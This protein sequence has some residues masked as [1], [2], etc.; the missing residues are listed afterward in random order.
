MFSLGHFIW[1][2]ILAVVIIT[3]LVLLKK[4]NVSH[5]LVGKVV[6][7]IAI[8]GKLIHLMLSLKESSDGG[9]VI[10]QTQLDFHLCSIQV[11]LMITCHL[12]KNQDTV[13]KIKGFMA[14]TMAIGA[15][16]ALLIPTEGVSPAVPRV[17]QYMIIHGNLVFYGFYLMLVEK[18]DLGVKTYVRNLIAFSGFAM[19]GFMMNSILEAYNT[20]FLYLRKPPMDNLPILNL[21]NGYLAY[22][23]TLIFVAVLLLTSVHLAFIIRELKNKRK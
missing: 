12:V 9:M 19:L 5:A 6:M 14:P 21:N 22:I 4:Y 8:V 23:A 13:K 18:I 16:M 10:N 11:Y 20:N 7:V 15:L 2:G 17:W 3:A 1:L